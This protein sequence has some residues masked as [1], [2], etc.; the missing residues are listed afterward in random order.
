[1]WQSESSDCTCCKAPEAAF[2][3]YAHCIKMPRC[4]GQ[5]AMLY[6]PDSQR[7]SRNQRMPLPLL[8]SMLPCRSR[9]FP[10]VVVAIPES[11]AS[12]T[13]K[14]EACARDCHSSHCLPVNA[15]LYGMIQPD[16]TDLELVC[17]GCSNSLLQLA[18]FFRVSLKEDA[19]HR[20]HCR[21]FGC[22][23]IG[24]G[25]RGPPAWM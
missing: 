12:S 7:E 19:P 6:L 21:C 13:T 10:S 8:P 25:L 9:A 2:T 3:L 5:T 14:R 20:W 17:E 22:L 23:S 11:K 16:P 4:A 1:M 18:A 24:Q 15:Y